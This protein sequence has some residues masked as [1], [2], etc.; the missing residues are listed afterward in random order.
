MPTGLPTAG[1]A[2]SDEGAVLTSPA[3]HSPL[4][5]PCQDREHGCRRHRRR[6]RPRRSGRH[7][8][9]RRRRASGCCCSTRSPSRASAARR[10]GRSAGCSSSTPPSSAGWAS[11]T[12]T[13]SPC[14]TG[15]AARSSTAR[16]PLA[17]ALGRGVRRL[18]GRREAA[19]AARPGPADLPGRRLG[20]A[21][22]RPRGRARQLGA[23]LPHHLGHRPRRGRAVRAPGARGASPK[24]L[25]TFGFRHRVDG[26]VKDGGVVTGVRG[27][28]ARARRHGA[29]HAP[30]TATR[31][32]S[33]ST[34]PRP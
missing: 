19:L 25:V 23:A 17:A 13:S 20:R 32:A 28:R 27:A 2:A 30:A 3:C 14:R 4:S 11:R 10:S 9:A 31:S 8:R 16:G 33:S 6:S 24:G 22:R 12:P 1:S 7:R 15:W 26:L 34:P 29:R 5:G 21:R 18:R